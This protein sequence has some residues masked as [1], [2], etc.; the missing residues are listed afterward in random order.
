MSFSSTQST[1]EDG[2]VV[3]ALE[4]ELDL[5]SSPDLKDLLLSHVDA[6]PRLVA[7]LSGVT[8]LDSSGMG[9]LLAAKKRMLA[10]GKDFAIANP[11]G[12]P[13][14]ALQISGLCQMIGEEPDEC[15]AEAPPAVQ[16]TG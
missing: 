2:T 13:E 8:F 6:A 9:L 3:L 1:R 4:G 7:D 15:E 12:Q 14:R 16:T 11:K 5:V 10:R